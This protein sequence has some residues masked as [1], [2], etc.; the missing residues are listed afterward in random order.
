M[1]K[2][3]RYSLESNVLLS[4]KHRIRLWIGHKRTDLYVQRVESALYKRMGWDGMHYLDHEGAS[5]NKSHHSL[6][7]SDSKD[8]CI[9]YV[10]FANHTFRGCSNGIMISRFVVAPRYQHKGLSVIILNLVGAMLSASGYVLYFNTELPWFGDKVGKSGCWDGTAND[11]GFR[12][13]PCDARNKHRRSG[14]AW[15]KKYVGKA[16]R[17]YSDLFLKVGV[18]RSRMATIKASECVGET[19]RGY[20]DVSLN[21]DVSHSMWA[22]ITAFRVTLRTGA[23]EINIIVEQITD[24]IWY[25]DSS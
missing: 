22:N 4:P 8:R 6:I 14:V 7:F 5:F 10:A 25:E 1:L 20:S 13:A 21:A 23:D 24:V 2:L 16:L 11:V 17:G 9:A 12:N 19:L 18:L 15:R 3:N